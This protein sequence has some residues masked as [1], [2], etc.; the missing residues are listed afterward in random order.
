MNNQSIENLE[1]E[2]SLLDIV[3]F[4]RE[5]W[6][7]ILVSGIVGGTLGVGYALISPSIY[8]ATANIQVSKVAGS[9]VE[10]PSVLIEK[11]KMPMY[12]TQSTFTACN[13]MD[14]SEPGDAI[15]K[16]IKPTLSKNTPIISITYKEKSTE[17]AKKCLEGVLSDIR[18]NQNILAKPILE[19]K[20]NQLANLKQKLESAEKISKILSTKNPNF[21]FSDSQFSASTLL[22]VTT[23]NKENEVKDLRAKIGDLEIA[24]AEPQ[25][26]EASLSTPIYAPSA[27]VEPNRSRIVLLG[28]IV[29]GVLAIAY[30]L[31]RRVWLKANIPNKAI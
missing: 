31:G 8:Q 19:T 17:D 4:F 15:A 7:Q 23:L 30:L 28:G 18:T 27:R 26:K 6:K 20:N 9:D 11:L 25:T 1:D 24:L 16:G 5:S 22:L 21:D 2:I 29:G 3:D 10:T 12:Y 14:R 13:V